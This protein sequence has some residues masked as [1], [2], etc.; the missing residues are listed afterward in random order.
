MQDPETHDQ[1]ERLFSELEQDVE[2]D[3]PPSQYL[4]ALGGGVEV[5]E[6]PKEKLMA[7]LDR[8]LLRIL[9]TGWI[10]QVIESVSR[11]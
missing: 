1:F 7:M 5:E 2:F 4:S 6:E 9:Q 11:C 8:K 3:T 10:R